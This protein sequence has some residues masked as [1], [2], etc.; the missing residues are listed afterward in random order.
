MK[1]DGIYEYIRKTLV[2]NDGDILNPI[3]SDMFSVEDITKIQKHR[4]DPQ[5]IF[6]HFRGINGSIPL[7]FFDEESQEIIK[8]FIKS[9]SSKL[10]NAVNDEF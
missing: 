9:R 4:S 6:I 10:W 1:K 2:K 5:L 8:N 7:R 3:T